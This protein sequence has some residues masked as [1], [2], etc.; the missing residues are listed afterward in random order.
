MPRSYAVVLGEIKERIRTARLRM[1]MA[2]QIFKD[3]YLFDFLGAADPRR[4]REIEQALRRLSGQI[5][6]GH[7]VS[8]MGYAAIAG[9]YYQKA[10]AEYEKYHELHAGDP[11]PVEKDFIR[12]VTEVKVMEKTKKPLKKKRTEV[13]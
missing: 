9:I 6:P 13:Q 4:E 12:V 11:S 3:P 7:P 10:R 8:H 5:S 1:V 2:A